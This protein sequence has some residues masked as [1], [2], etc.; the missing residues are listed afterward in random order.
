M[1]KKELW[2]RMWDLNPRSQAYEACEID[3][4]SPIRCMSPS[5]DDGSLPEI[6]NAWSYRKDLNLQPPVYKTDVLPIELL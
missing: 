3:L 6:L 4:A 1:D 5:G 2:L